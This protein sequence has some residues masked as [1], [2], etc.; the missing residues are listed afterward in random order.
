MKRVHDYTSSERVSSPEASPSS[1]T[2]GSRKKDNPARKRKGPNAAGAQS[3]K[4]TRSAQSQKSALKMAQSQAHHSQQLENAQRNYYNCLYRLQQELSKLNPEDPDQ[5]DKANASLQELH[6]LGL[7]YRSMQA[8]Q[9]ASE[10]GRS[11]S[12]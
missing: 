4:R 7:N 11:F 3:M 10:A 5:H 2:Q 6:T 8:G 1:S 12:A 9:A